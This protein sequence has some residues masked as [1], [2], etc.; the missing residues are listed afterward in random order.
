MNQEQAKR[1]LPAIQAFAEGKAVQVRNGA[2]GAWY[3][4]SNPVWSPY[5]DYRVKPEP[6]KPREIFVNEYKD[7]LSDYYWH[8]QGDA[9]N[10]GN[11][12]VVRIVK[13]REVIEE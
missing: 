5:Q 4:T 8:L 11:E 7:G 10:A 3:D 2:T 13:F 12:G 1:L 9:A 6:P